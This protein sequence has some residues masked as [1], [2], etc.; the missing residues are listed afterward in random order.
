MDGHERED[1]VEYRKKFLGQM[2]TLGFLSAAN[3]PTDE[4]KS[5]LHDDLE[6]PPPTV[7]DKTVVFFHD[8]S[9]FLCNDDQS[10]FWE[11]KGT[12]IIKPK[13]K[14]AG[15]M[16]SDFIDE[17]NG[18]L[19]LT[20][21][22]YDRAK[23]SAPNNRMH[24]RELFEYGEAKE[25]YWTSEKFM[26]QVSR[27]VEIAEVKYPKEEGWKHVWIFDHSSRHAAMSEDCLRCQQNECKSWRETCDAG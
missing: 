25:G 27:A 3:A 2:V 19:A 12:H 20:K 18:Y 6:C 21:E 22:E 11:E 16:V 23:V 4:A 7:L 14:G 8:E 17:K 5:A 9:T 10:T 13:S 1:V 15:I 24:V 26:E